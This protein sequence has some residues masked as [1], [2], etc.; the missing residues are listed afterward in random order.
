MSISHGNLAPAGIAL[1]SAAVGFFLYQWFETEEGAKEPAV[2]A[3][4]SQSAVSVIG[5][6]L[7]H[8]AL[9]DPSGEPRTLSEWRGRPMLINFWATWCSPCRKE[10]PEL[11]ELQREFRDKGLV[12]VGI[13]LDEPERVRRFMRDFGIDYPVLVESGHGTRMS[14]A[15]GNRLG[16]LPYTV[17]VDSSGVIREAH[18]GALTR[19]QGR[20]SIRRL[21]E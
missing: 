2:Q 14:A 8:V 3:T 10:V 12:V 18:K 15:F 20:E 1:V 6:P 17:Y 4:Y 7:P 21:F 11:I 9:P 16:V 19:D 5:E 13:A